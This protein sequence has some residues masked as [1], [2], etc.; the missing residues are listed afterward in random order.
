MKKNRL[1]LAGLLAVASGLLA[2][3][4]D[5]A[6]DPAYSDLALDK[7]ELV[8]DLDKGGEGVILITKGNGN[9]K[10]TTSNEN[11][12]TVE[13]RGDSLIVTG[14]QSGK[15]DIAITDWVKK[16]ASAKVVV[17]RLEE[18]LLSQESINL[19][20]G[21]SDSLAVYTGNGGYTVASSD[22]SV[23]VAA[24]DEEGKITIS[25]VKR[26]TATFTVTDQLKKSVTFTANV[27]NPLLLDR[28]ED[29]YM[30]ET[31]VPF[32]IGILD[33]NGGYTA[34]VSSSSYLECVVTGTTVTVKGKRFGKA[35]ATFTVKDAD[36]IT[37][38]LRV[39]FVDNNYLDNLNL[40]RAFVPD[41][42]PF[43][44]AGGIG[45]AVYSPELR[46]SQLSAKTSTSIV[47]TG[48]CVEFA[49]DLSVGSKQDGILYW[50]KRGQVDTSTAQAVT[51]LRIDKVDGDWHWAS[52]QMTGKAT[53]GYIV[54]KRTN[55]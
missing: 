28:T 31:G 52:F 33:G 1:Y 7:E 54:T 18:L 9:Y 3:C 13:A 27:S 23:A 12:A 45:T 21:Q 19:F 55:K 40:Y 48:Y 2:G 22:N 49:G 16:S 20:T 30:L 11:V 35:N 17:K 26:G 4:G 10:V 50:I 34:S 15:A 8:I 38:T 37:A 24:V 44:Q 5:N 36:N 41:D 25:G 29:I 43:Q 51:D 39:M 32:E 47:A 42:A 6:D 53:R 46:R 14:L